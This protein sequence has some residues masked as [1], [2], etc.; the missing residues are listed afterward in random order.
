MAIA[1][2]SALVTM[3]LLPTA[4]AAYVDGGALAGT[5]V[6]VAAGPGNQSDPHVSGDLVTYTLDG[7]SIGFA[8]LATGASGV[9][10]KPV[11]AHDVLSD[12]SGSRIA[13]VRWDD[14][15]GSNIVVHDL[16]TGTS[17]VLDPQAEGTRTNPAIGGDAVVFEDLG[18]VRIFDLASGAITLLANGSQP[19]ISSDGTL[20]TWMSG[21]Q[22]YL[23]RRGASDWTTSTT[24]VV[25]DVGAGF[26]PAID[27]TG[28]SGI[29][30]YAGGGDIHWRVRSASGTLG[31]E[32]TVALPGVDVDPSV[33]GSV[34]LFRHQLHD[35]SSTDVF[36]FDAS[37]GVLN[38]VTN[39][40]GVSETLSDV[41]VRA[42]GSFVLVWVVR[43][44]LGDDDVLGFVTPPTA[45]G[46]AFGGFSAPVNNAP[47]INEAR[48]GQTIA[49]KWR[50]TDAAGAPITDPLSFTSLTSSS[51]SCDLGTA[52]DAIE[53]YSGGSG[54]QYLGDGI[55]QFNWKTPKAYAGQ[56]R[57]MSLNLADGTS[58][59][60]QFWFR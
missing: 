54:L 28:D 39:T 9:V 13:F 48:A 5:P 8:D 33:A 52:T 3:T 30:A 41:S 2:I 56:C 22:V 26:A 49:V 43:S 23:A 21:G 25:T 15:T 53:T 17:T 45:V 29:L 32:Q 38:S 6:T 36:F 12:V 18:V 7:T 46:Y 42:D 16:A 60:A 40:P 14:A 27:G 1:A 50:L 31:P 47:T 35:G 19:A 58:Y 34:I 11:G 57:A 24:Q 37:T 20:V 55:W 4:A 44:A 51:A 10:P 59:I